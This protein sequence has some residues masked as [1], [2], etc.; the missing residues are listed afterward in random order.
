M[1]KILL[2]LLATAVVLASGA[3]AYASTATTTMN[4]SASV[5]SAAEVSATDMNFGSIPVGG[6]D[7]SVQAQSTISVTASNGT[8]YVITLDAGQ[9]F[10]GI[11]Y[12]SM[13]S[14]SNRMYYAISNPTFTSIWGD[15]SYANTY[16]VG[17]GVP[18]TGTGAVQ[19]YTA[20]GTIESP[21]PAPG[22][23]SDVV[24]VTVNY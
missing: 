6:G 15:A 7:G 19:P 14:G 22:N 18:G 9:H 17:N 2:S 8:P 10:D 21:A 23:Y 20:Y 13:V 3:S 5:V 4:V 24:T 16:P 12:R 1:K 11:Y